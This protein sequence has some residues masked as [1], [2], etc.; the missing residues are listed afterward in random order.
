M[1]VCMRMLENA[2]FFFAVKLSRLILKFLKGKENGD[3][4][5]LREGKKLQTIKKAICIIFLVSQT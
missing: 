4:E 1:H 2:T 5:N 3:N